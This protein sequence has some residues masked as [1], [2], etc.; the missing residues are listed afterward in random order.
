MRTLTN[1]NEFINTCANQGTFTTDVSIELLQ[2]ME[3]RQV[4]FGIQSISAERITVK[5]YE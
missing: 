3:N 1:W 5:V 2:E 4:S